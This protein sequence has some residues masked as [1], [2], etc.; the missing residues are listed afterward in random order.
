MTETL[1]VRLALSSIWD[2]IRTQLLDQQ[3]GPYPKEKIIIG[4][5]IAKREPGSVVEISRLDA[6]AASL[7]WKTFNEGERQAL[8]DPRLGHVVEMLAYLMG[9]ESGLAVNEASQ[10]GA[11]LAYNITGW[12]GGKNANP[13]MQRLEQIAKQ[14]AFRPAVMAVLKA[15]KQGNPSQPSKTM[16]AV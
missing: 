9:L 6:L 12:N 2:F 8:Q 1:E 4:T 14:A 5:G 7:A 16:T 11:W 13:Y 10:F 3:V 15:L